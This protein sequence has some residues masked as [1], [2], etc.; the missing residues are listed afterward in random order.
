MDIVVPGFNYTALS[1]LRCLQPLVREGARLWSVGFPETPQ[2]AAWSRLPRRRIPFAAGGWAD[3]LLAL[4]NR[5]TARPVLLPTSD[6]QALAVARDRKRLG[7]IYDFLL[8]D[9]GVLEQLTE[10]TRFYALAADRGWPVARTETAATPDALLDLPGRMRLPLI[11]KPFLRHAHRVDTPEELAAYARTLRPDHYRAL[12]AQEWIEG[13]DDAIYFSFLLYDRE[14]RRVRTFTGRKLRQWPPRSGSTSLGVSVT[15]ETI[16]TLSAEMLESLAFR[17]YGSVEFKRDARTGR[18]VV[19]EPTAG[20]FNLQI[21]LSAAAG[22]NI[23]ADLCRL[24]LGR[25]LPGARVRPGVHWILESDDWKSHHAQRTDYGY[26]RNFFRRRVCVLFAWHD[27]LPFAYE[28]FRRLGNALRN[29]AARL[30][31]SRPRPAR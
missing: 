29:L 13:A 4:G 15:N 31:G 30:T 5:F 10:K 17:G 20:R 19:M 11:V 18:F 12:V 6:E 9:T 1:T 3:N 21:A 24:I 23:P 26:V 16:A 25:P 22:M 7:D 14:G 27:P 2:P 28:A 8:P